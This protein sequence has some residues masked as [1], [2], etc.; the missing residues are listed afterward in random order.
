MEGPQREIVYNDDD[1]MY[2]LDDDIPHESDESDDENNASSDDD[3]I[4]V[5]T[6]PQNIN[7]SVANE[8]QQ[9]KRRKLERS[10]K[11]NYQYTIE[12]N[13]LRRSFRRKTVRF[14]AENHLPIWRESEYD[15]DQ[16]EVDISIYRLSSFP[17]LDTELF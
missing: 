6:Q 2:H 9:Y 12:N 5:I 10:R 15:L 13:G 4:T 3:D 16:I 1:E 11:N 8:Y 14:E 7:P 17:Y